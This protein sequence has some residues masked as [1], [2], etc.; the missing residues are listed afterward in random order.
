[1][2]AGLRDEVEV[3]NTGP[4]P[5]YVEIEVDVASDL[6][7]LAAARAGSLRDADEVEPAGSDPDEVLLVRG[8]GPSRIGCRVTG[9]GAIRSQ[10][11]TLRWEA[12]VPARGRYSVT[13]AVSPILEGAEVVPDTLL[14]S[15]AGRSESARRLVQWHRHVPQ[16]TSDHLPLLAAVRRSAADLG[17]LRVIDPEFPEQ[18]VV[19]AGAPGTWR[20][21]GATPC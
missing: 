2:A 3:R 1:M 11:A 16:V 4:E 5:S 17:A 18:A 12:I 13:V 21:T 20:C 19:A 6:A 8:R 15:D 10:P 7:P 14:A 9:A